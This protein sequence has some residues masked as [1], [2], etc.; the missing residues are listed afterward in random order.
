MLKRGV[1]AAL[2]AAGAMAIAACE[3]YSS[4]PTGTKESVSIPYDPY[5]YNPD[6]L[7]DRANAH[8]RAYGA[9]GARYE[10]ET[11]DPNAV[12]WRYRHFRCV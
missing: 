4:T 9:R 7:Q 1:L 10:D 5:N 2:A 11:I 12:R 8:C 3:T 6:E